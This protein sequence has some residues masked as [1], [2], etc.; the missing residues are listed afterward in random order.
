VGGD[1][2]DAI[3]LPGGRL[4][5]SIGDVVGRGA[6]AA[7]TMAQLRNALRAYALEGLSPG[8]AL[9]RLDRLAEQ[10]GERDFATALCL[11]LDPASG[12]LRFANAGHLPP[13]VLE[14]EG[15]RF[16]EG[17]RSIPLGIQAA[18]EREEDAVRLQP[19]TVLVLYTDGLVEARTMALGDGLNKLL[20]A[21]A[22]G[23]RDP[24]R[25]LDHLLERL[26]A[27]DP[28]RQDDVA[29]LAFQLEPEAA[30]RL[31]VHFD[32]SP[33]ALGSL[34][35]QL[36]DWLSE[37]GLDSD[38]TADVLVAVGEACANAI[39]HPRDPANATVHVQARVVDGEL[40]VRIRDA[41][42]W[43]PPQERAWRGFGLLLMEQLMD[44]VDVVPSATGTQVHLRRR[45]RSVPRDRLPA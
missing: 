10:L 18:T 45:V 40:R 38:E 37:V 21:A 39:E 24:D 25:L 17:A 12:E 19:G 34:R 22:E 29:A 30:L 5:L 36:R 3:P 43:R 28:S 41:G 32:A 14:G 15:A 20:A 11:E 9:E 2:F 44:E 33:A 4:G 7:A 23:P 27:F 35:S 13:L 31:D 42:G 1:W 16:L 8:R 6:R 26:G